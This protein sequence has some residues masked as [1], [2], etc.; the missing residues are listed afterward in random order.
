VAAA[1]EGGRL[2]AEAALEAAVEV[3][4]PNELSQHH[5]D[6]STPTAPHRL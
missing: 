2:A 1:E 6:S 5:V 4:T 3:N